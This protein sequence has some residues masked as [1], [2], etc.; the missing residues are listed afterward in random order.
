M[1]ATTPTSAKDIVETAY[2]AIGAGDVATF[3]GL[4]ADDCVLEEPAG[5][6]AAGT[7]TGPEE[8]QG[9]FGG[10]AGALG[11]RGV[12]VHQ[13]IAEGDRAIGL[14]DVLL[15]SKSGAESTMSVCEVWDVRDGK[16]VHIR[17]HYWDTAELQKLATS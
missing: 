16:V 6:P 15:T 12:T 13:V 3:I 5:H 7:W 1:S 17:P 11:L 9:G 4:L 8:I 14:V 10:I 2:A